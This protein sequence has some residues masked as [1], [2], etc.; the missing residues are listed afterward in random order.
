M[1]ITFDLL[2]AIQHSLVRWKVLTKVLLLTPPTPNSATQLESEITKLPR[3][4]YSPKKKNSLSENDTRNIYY[5][6]TGDANTYNQA[7]PI[8]FGKSKPMLTG[9][10]SS[11]FH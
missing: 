9:H 5:H 6:K 10:H 4:N 7:K 8:P 3:F 11:K 1:I 2:N